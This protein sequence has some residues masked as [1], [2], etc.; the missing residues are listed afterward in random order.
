V[1]AW[2]SGSVSYS[3]GRAHWKIGIKTFDDNED[4]SGIPA[5]YTSMGICNASN[6]DWFYDYN[7]LDSEKFDEMIYEHVL[8]G[9]RGRYIVVRLEGG[10]R[11]EQTA[12]HTN[13]S[14]S[15]ELADMGLSYRL[16]NQK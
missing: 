6:Y 3:D 13:E 1:D 11:L 9:T 14:P 8:G 4:G 7:T 16:K 5:P 10:E 12:G 15:V 2:S